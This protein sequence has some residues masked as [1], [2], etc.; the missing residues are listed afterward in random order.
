MIPSYLFSVPLHEQDQGF[1][2]LMTALDMAMKWM[3]AL[4]QEKVNQI[5]K[6]VIEPLKMLGSVFRSLT[7]W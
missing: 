6:S 2:N 5:Q 4:S 1:L 3:D 7:R